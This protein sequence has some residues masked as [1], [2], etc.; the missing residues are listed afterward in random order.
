MTA[1]A[2]RTHAAFRRQ[3]CSVFDQDHAKLYFSG[4]YE[5][6]SRKLLQNSTTGNTCEIGYKRFYSFYFQGIKFTGPNG[7]VPGEFW[8]PCHSKKY[9]GASG[10]FIMSTPAYPQTPD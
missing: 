5:T 6:I 10:P 2:V 3:R 9:I 7:Q 1:A 4:N 8:W